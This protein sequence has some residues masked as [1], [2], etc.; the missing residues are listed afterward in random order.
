MPKY[1]FNEQCSALEENI[2]VGNVGLIGS[3]GGQREANS[4]SAGRK[5]F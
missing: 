2:N 1:F 4:V 5:R 3:T